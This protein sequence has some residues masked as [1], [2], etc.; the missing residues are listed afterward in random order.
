MLP[1]YAGDYVFRSAYKEMEDLSDNVVW[2]SIPAVDEGRLIDMSFGLFFYN[3]IYS[4][5]KQLDFVVDSLLE[6]VK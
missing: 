3:D 1:E 5:D 6:T 4:L 2:N